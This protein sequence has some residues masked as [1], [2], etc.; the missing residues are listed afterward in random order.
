MT[1]SLPRISAQRFFL[2]RST[3]SRGSPQQTASST[4]LIKRSAPLKSC[5]CICHLTFRMVPDDPSCGETRQVGLF[6]ELLHEAADDRNETFHVDQKGIVPLQ[7]GKA[8]ELGLRAALPQHAG[9]RFL[10]V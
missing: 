10:L 3:S 6:G 4:A 5:N 1:S 9:E 8:L 2:M 7:R